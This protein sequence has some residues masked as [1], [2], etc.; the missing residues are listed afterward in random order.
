MIQGPKNLKKGNINKKNL[1]AIK[2][3]KL[4]KQKMSYF[5]YLL[6]KINERH[7]I[8]LKVMIILQNKFI[9]NELKKTFA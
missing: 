2:I 9:R 8:I 6:N 7:K 3:N 4:F 5:L 1:L